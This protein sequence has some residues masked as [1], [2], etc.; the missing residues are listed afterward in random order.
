MY[1]PIASVVSVVYDVLYLLTV[2]Q[3]LSEF[4]IL[5]QQ[6]TSAPGPVALH[7]RV[8]LLPTGISLLLE[9]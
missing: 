2:V 4:K 8:M 7:K 1:S 9:G 3:L 6:Y 5:S